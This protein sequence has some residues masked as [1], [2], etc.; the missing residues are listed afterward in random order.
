MERRKDNKGRVLKQGESQRKD[1]IYQYRY[2]NT[3]G[4]RKTIY[5]SSLQ[6]L[7]EKEKTLQKD[8][9]NGIDYSK[10]NITVLELF[11]K[12]V[13]LKQNVK[14]N[15][16][17]NYKFVLN[18]V[19]K[20]QFGKRKITTV[21]ISDAK[22]WFVDIQKRGKKYNT[23]AKIKG[24][25]KPAFQMACDDDIIMKNPFA[26]KMTDVVTNDTEYR[27]ALTNEELLEW[28]TF[29]KNDNTY[30][31]YYNEIV[32][33]LETGIRVSEMCGLTFADLDFDA[34]QIHINRQL[35]KTKDRGLMV[36][37]TKTICGT[38]TIPMTN[39]TYNAL[40]IILKNRPKVSKEYCVDGYTN[41]VFIQR[42]GEPK[43][44]MHIQDAIS[45]ANQK[46]KK[47]FPDKHLPKISPHVLRHTFC[48]N[49][50]N[51]GMSIKSLQYL[52]GHSDANV[53]LNVYSHSSFPSA[54]KEMLQMTNFEDKY[55]RG[56]DALH[57]ST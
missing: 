28:M 16:K 21:K 35:I 47:T 13:K 37:T 46:Y 53:T 18:F 40:K 30:S 49:Y 26:F 25:A 23:I 12:Y 51:S 14:Y 1:L 4:V 9:N 20:E 32:V 42:N 6:E 2:T 15:T 44:A 19:S 43:S 55:T 29:I 54:A 17:V 11:T 24:I 45:N 52:M 3:N 57:E 5:S 48:T 39:A 41:F 50:A 38:R 31:V 10:G 36:E 22:Q 56:T 27:V 34:R 33:L 7:R 8:L